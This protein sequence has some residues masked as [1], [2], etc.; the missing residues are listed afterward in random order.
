MSK[1]RKKP[2]PSGAPGN[3]SRIA[4]LKA[5]AIADNTLMLP[6]GAN[7]GLPTLYEGMAAFVGAGPF[8]YVAKAPNAIKIRFHRLLADLHAL[9]PNSTVEMI[10]GDALRVQAR[11]VS[12]GAKVTVADFE[13]AVL[14]KEA[15]NW[16]QEN[17]VE[18]AVSVPVNWN[19]TALVEDV[20]EAIQEQLSKL[21][22][23]GKVLHL[24]SLDGPGSPNSKAGFTSA[25]GL[26]GMEGYEQFGAN[27]PAVAL[28][29][30]CA[31]P[32]LWSP[33]MAATIQDAIENDL[34]EMV[35]LIELR[36]GENRRSALNARVDINVAVELLNSY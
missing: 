6:T 34:L 25:G 16:M 28:T 13:N 11:A 1:K 5:L 31:E 36:L 35:L 15:F 29:L 17:L 32:D 4:V 8:G 20:N 2:G 7:T 27:I 19:R 18:V 24:D 9:P 23:A 33:D 26:N 3:P 12:S 30:T 14:V 21:P 22:D 10:T